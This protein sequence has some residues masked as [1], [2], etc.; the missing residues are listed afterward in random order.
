MIHSK[1]LPAIVNV[2]QVPKRSPFRYPGGKTWL[3]PYLRAWLR[4]LARPQLFIEPFVG[5]GIISLSVGFENLADGV[6]MVE[7]DEDVAAVWKTLLS[8]DAKWLS[9]KILDF[10]ISVEAVRA[11]LAKPT[12]STRQRA[13]HTILKNRTYHGGIL[14]HGSGL[15][16][17]G[18]GGKGIKSRWYAATLSQRIL[19][20]WEIRSRFQFSQADGLAYMAERVGEKS[21]V[22]FI[23]PPYTAGGKGKRA[24]RRLYNHNELDHKRLFDLAAKVQGD[25]LMTYDNDPEVLA[26]AKKRGFDTEVVPMKNTHHEKM[27][28]LL[29][30]KDLAWARR[31]L[32]PKMLF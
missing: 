21:T 7:L 11:E 6:A 24:G 20:I 28:E 13:F 9:E 14:A 23:D 22:F 32:N 4:S 25:F 27:V 3:V 30:G 16:K 8:K 19:N 17:L 1:S 26:M 29:I 10:D 5:G 18:E 31:M 15:V 2:A 12:R